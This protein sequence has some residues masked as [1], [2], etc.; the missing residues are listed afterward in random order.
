[1]KIFKKRVLACIVDSLIFALIIASCQLAI[2]WFLAGRGIVL[3]LWFVPF[4]LRD[5]LFRNASLGKKLFNIAVYDKNWNKPKF[6][7]LIKRSFLTSTVGYSLFLKSRFSERRILS[8]FDWERDKLGTQVVDVR[9][10]KLIDQAAKEE[11]GDFIANKS[12]LYNQYLR[13][14]YME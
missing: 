7:L 3:I 8:L 2:P 12:R 11:N 9:V 14:L 6:G 5:L 4:F 10:L 1:M 13:D